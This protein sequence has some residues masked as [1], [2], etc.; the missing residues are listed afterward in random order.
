MALASGTVAVGTAATQINGASANPMKLHISNNDNSDTVYL[1]D[2]GVTPNFGLKL[3]KLERIVFELNPG[4][5]I[6]A[7]STKTG[8]VVSYITQ[9]F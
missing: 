7:V 5:R 6:F 8:H 9:T 4:E 1:G 3:Q 2:E